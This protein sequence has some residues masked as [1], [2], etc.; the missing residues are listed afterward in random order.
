MG[1]KWNVF[2]INFHLKDC[3][4]ANIVATTSEYIIALVWHLSLTGKCNLTSLACL[5][6]SFTRFIGGTFVPAY[7][8]GPPC[9]RESGLG[10]RT[11]RRGPS[12]KLGRLPAW[13][14]V[15]LR[16]VC[17]RIIGL[18]DDTQ[19]G[20]HFLHFR[21]AGRPSCR[22]RTCYKRSLHTRSPSSERSAQL[23]LNF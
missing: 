19:R 2:Y 23:L 15:E 10:A 13:R 1:S 17:C 3:L 18:T 5:F 8:F 11:A 16:R 21:S 7:C 9:M 4:G 12:I 22:T 6:A 14:R 20:S